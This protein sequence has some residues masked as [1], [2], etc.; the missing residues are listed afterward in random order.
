MCV[1]SRWKLVSNN[2][3]I[4][5]QYVREHTFRTLKTVC[6][7]VYA[8]NAIHHKYYLCS[9]REGREG[10]A[11]WRAREDGESREAAG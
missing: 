4:Y 10:A 9:A 7:C 6:V 1:T 2:G 8:R 5:K 3:R 11:S